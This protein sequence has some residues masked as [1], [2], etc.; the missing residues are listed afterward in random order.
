MEVLL[1]KDAHRAST[2]ARQASSTARWKVS[3]AGRKGK[4][5]SG[6]ICNE[7]GGEYNLLRLMAVRGCGKLMVFT[8][9]AE[10]FLHKNK[11]V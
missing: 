5:L 1:A 2:R 11:M 7:T 4:L 8:P 3:L 9:T 10:E 6:R